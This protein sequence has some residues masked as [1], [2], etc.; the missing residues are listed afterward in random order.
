MSEI[1]G[2]SWM[3][4]KLGF[5]HGG[6]CRF[7]PA[8]ARLTRVFRK[9]REL[10]TPNPPRNRCLLYDWVLQ[11]VTPGCPAGEPRSDRDGRQPGWAQAARPGDDP[12]PEFRR[13][14]QPEAQA[15]FLAAALASLLQSV[16][17]VNEEVN[18]HRRNLR[19]P[20][21]GRPV[22]AP[23]LPGLVRITNGAHKSHF[24]AGA[25]ARRRKPGD[26][27]AIQYSGGGNQEPKSTLHLA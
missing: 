26:Q 7:P 14:T 25:E 13:V 4:P 8:P 12:D 27:H 18:Q 10:T 11:R 20:G 17:V 19:A 22:V 5:R 15:T 1:L 9:L 3:I 2:F 23:G 21:W 6:L 24:F 16:P